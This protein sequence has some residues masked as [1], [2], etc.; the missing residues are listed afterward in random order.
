MSNVGEDTEWT[1]A[2][3]TDGEDVNWAENTLENRWGTSLVMQWL[4]LYS[5]CRGPRFYPDQ[6][7]PFN[8]TVIQVYIPTSNAE[9]AEV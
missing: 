2:L 4:R 9:K 6:G 8:I 5:Q 3:D 7:K 1:T